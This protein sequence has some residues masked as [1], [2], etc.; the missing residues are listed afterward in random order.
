MK[1]LEPGGDLPYVLRVGVADN[2]EMIGANASPR[3]SRLRYSAR[4]NDDDTQ[5]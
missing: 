3:I 4:T 2:E 1:E 5:K